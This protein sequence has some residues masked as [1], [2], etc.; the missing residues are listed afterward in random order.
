MKRLASLVLAAGFVLSSL[1]VTGQG[2]FATPFSDVPA[3]HWAYQALQ[4]L[5][6]DGLVEGYPDG[7]FKGDRPLSRYEMAVLVARVIAKVEANGAS[8]ADLDKLQKLIDALKDELD[9]LG[10]RVTNLE[11]ALDALDKRTK[12]AQSVEFHG[13][14]QPNVSERER[15]QFAK[16]VNGTAL[17]PEPVGNFVNTFL[18]SDDS[19]NPLSATGGGIRIRDE[20]KFAFTYHFND[21]IDIT[22]PVHILTFDFGGEYAAGSSAPHINFDP[23][24]AIKVGKAGAL[25]NLVFKYGQID[26]MKASRT[27]LTFAPPIGT[28]GGQ[29]GPYFGY[30]YPLQ[31]DQRGMSVAGTIL[32][33]TDFR[34]SFTR[35]DQVFITTQAGV[36]GDPS[37]DANFGYL[38]AIVPSQYGLQQPNAAGVLT[39]NSFTAGTG[40]LAQVYLTQKGVLGSVF[41]SAYNGATYN[42]NRSLI[43]GPPGSL[44]VAPA[45]TYN[46]AT[47]A[48]VFNPPLPAGSTVT[49][50]YTGLNYT[51]NTVPQ[52]YMIN[53]RVNQRIKGW[54]GAEIGVT[55]NRIFDFDDIQVSGTLTGITNNTTSSFGFGLVSNTVLGVDF[56]LPLPYEVSGKGS[57]PII[58]GEASASKFTA[59]YRNVPAQTDTAGVI[60]LRL[61][62]QSA[63]ISATYQSIGPGYLDGAPFR[64]YGNA[65]PLFSFWKLPYFPSFFG[66]AN[67][68]GINLQLDNAFTAIAKTN[69]NTANNPALTFIY[70]VFNQFIG[71]GQFFY[72]NAAYM[73]NTRGPALNI[74]APIKVGDTKF[75]ARLTARSLSEIRPNSFGQIVYGAGGASNVLETY[76]TIS[77][78][79][80]VVLP[81]FGQKVSLDVGGSWEKLRRND[82]TPAAYLPINPATGSIDAATAGAVATAFGIN[83]TTGAPNSPVSFFP[84][85]INDTRWTLSLRATVPIT[86]DVSLSGYYNT[87]RFGGSYG[88]TATQNISQRKDWYNGAVTYTIPK[89]TSS[90]SFSIKQYRYQDDVLP[91]FNATQ[92]RQDV[93][94]TVRF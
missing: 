62:I 70:P 37:G 57:N 43:A 56:Q 18:Y 58:F 11:D 74:T 81:A 92:N 44:A 64:W 53:A 67:P 69:P 22:L 86:R 26:D 29:S 1:L 84:N 61:K 41:V 13:L 47:N 48:V 34:V 90:V 89:T 39:S 42:S 8:K 76:N 77:G 28:T 25:T 38:N 4:S 5:A 66:F 91:T 52:R 78:G 32:G 87:Q 12:F 49:L 73:P 65:T 82:L 46:D 33:L 72:Q 20:A 63:D 6:A 40:P 51:G 59:D 83:P 60:G 79:V 21:Q 10:V 35:V 50:S 85:Y 36:N 16:N 88:T 15:F 31:P 30:T 2:A 93:N 94:F 71:G 75:N 55:F 17:A 19:N 14:F 80:G 23:S 3:N 9:A 54:K 7:K 27:G 45:F 24:L 68:A